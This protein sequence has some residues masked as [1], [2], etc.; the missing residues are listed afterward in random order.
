MKK[1]YWLQGGIISAFLFFL[2][3]IVVWYKYLIS[4]NPWDIMLIVSLYFPSLVINYFSDTVD[5]ILSGILAYAFYFGLGAILGWL[6]GKII[7]TAKS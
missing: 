5:F 7:L 4:D 2:V 6:Y 1:R 3:N